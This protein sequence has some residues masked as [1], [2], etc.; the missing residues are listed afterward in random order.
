MTDRKVNHKNNSVGAKRPSPVWAWPWW[1]DP[2]HFVFWTVMS[3]RKVCALAAPSPEHSTAQQVSLKGPGWPSRLSC[4]PHME[5]SNRL[6]ALPRK[7][8]GVGAERRKN[9]HSFQG[10]P[11]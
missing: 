6:L 2:H 11:A 8:P 4:I 7:F 5:S 1:V 10:F 9:M 3:T